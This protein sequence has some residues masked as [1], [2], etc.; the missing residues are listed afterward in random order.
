MNLLLFDKQ[1]NDW[2]YVLNSVNLRQNVQICDSDKYLLNFFCK[3]LFSSD[4]YY[5]KQ[6]INKS[7]TI[8]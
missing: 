2:L 6:W 8:E 7:S 5:K 1:L 4:S 3:D